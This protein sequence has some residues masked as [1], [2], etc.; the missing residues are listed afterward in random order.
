MNKKFSILCFILLPSC[1]VPLS[2][3]GVS[4]GGANNKM[5][6]KQ[7]IQQNINQT[8]AESVRSTSTSGSSTPIISTSSNQND[9]TKLKVG[10]TKT[11]VLKLF[12]QPDSVSIDYGKTSSMW[13]YR[14]PICVYETSCFISFDE[15]GL[16]RHYDDI[17]PYYLVL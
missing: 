14:K 6:I 3:G 12:G 16:V 7:D 1:I 15:K 5:D 8:T 2:I 4:V 13:F 10:Q 9:D 17:K 11:F